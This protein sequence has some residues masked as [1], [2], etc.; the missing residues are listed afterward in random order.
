[1]KEYIKPSIKT[2]SVEVLMQASTTLDPNGGSQTIII[3]G[4]DNGGGGFTGGAA[5]KEND[6]DVQ[7]YNVWA[8]GE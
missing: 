4:G 7:P 2:R 6:F 8:T 5:S 1:M 3:G